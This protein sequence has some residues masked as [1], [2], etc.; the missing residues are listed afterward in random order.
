M[1]A[2][3]ALGAYIVRCGG[4]SPLLG[5]KYLKSLMAKLVTDGS[6]DP[7]Y[8]DLWQKSGMQGYFKPGGGGFA[9]EDS[10]YRKMKELGLV[11]NGFAPAGSAND[12]PDLKFLASD[13]T[14][15]VITASTIPGRS[16]EY[17]CEIKLNAQA[18]FGQ[19][20]LK[21]TNGKWYLDGSNSAEARVMRSL[22]QN[23]EVPQKVNANWGP[24]GV[25]R[26][27]DPKVKVKTGSNMDPRDYM[28]DRETFK[29][30]MLTGTDAP[31]TRSLARYYGSKQTHYIQIG[32]YGLYYMQSDPANLKRHGVKRFDGTL[33]LRIRRKAGGS[34]REPWNYRFSTALLIDSPPS[35][36]GFSFDQA[37]EDILRALDPMGVISKKRR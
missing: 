24:L 22:L 2:T 26:K 21:Y 37:S 11:P 8:Y 17:K 16:R 23:M 6:S 27:F 31:Q 7:D 20:G 3:Y 33:K 1:V 13:V 36:S 4:S 30:I 14:A 32:G 18:D 25:P 10:L 28:F 5:T 9:Y 12:L 34:S 15:R 19:S 29:D 35:V